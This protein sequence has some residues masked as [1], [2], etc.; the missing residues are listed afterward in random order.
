[1]PYVLDGKIVP[2]KGIF[3]SELGSGQPVVLING[4]TRSSR[5][6]L[7]FETELAKNFRV[8]L[9]DN[10]GAGKS[11]S[12]P[13]KFGDS[14]DRMSAD[15]LSVLDALDIDRAHFI[16]LSL[17]GMIGLGA[18][19]AQPKRC[20]SLTMI[21][22]SIAGNLFPRLSARAILSLVHTLI[23][24]KDILEAAATY[25]ISGVSEE[26]KLWI[27]KQWQ[28]IAAEENIKFGL[29]NYQMMAAARYH[30]RKH[31]KEVRFPVLIFNA[32]DDGFVPI[33]NSSMLHSQIPGS[34]YQ[35]VDQGSHE[36]TAS[37]PEDTA[38][39][40]G[41]FMRR[42]SAKESQK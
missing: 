17:G 3:Y 30:V 23:G 18:C 28:E 39:R 16:G 6:W 40:I 34:E 5:H 41:E 14:I 4:M 7:G 9:I 27:M 38:A 20:L 13:T 21:N 8:I 36:V 29:I 12:V 22:S 42:A 1:M 2:K 10:R 33:I 24:K 37:R 26:R 32:R 11:Q 25:L 31:L 35:V 19:L 15:V